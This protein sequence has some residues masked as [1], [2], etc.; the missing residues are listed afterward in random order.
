MARVREAAETAADNLRPVG[1]LLHNHVLQRVHLCFPDELVVAGPRLRV[2]RSLLAVVVAPI[3]LPRIRD[4]LILQ[5]NPR[6]I[7][8]LLV[9]EVEL[10]GRA[11]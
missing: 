4:D 9:E 7:D 8:V 3:L 1:V 11:A 5:I 6:L 10:L 2:Y